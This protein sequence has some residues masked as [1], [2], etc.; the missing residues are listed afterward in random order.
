MDNS[1]QTNSMRTGKEQKIPEEV[2]RHLVASSE[3]VNAMD[4]GSILV[5]PPTSLA[6]IR[7]PEN[8]TNNPNKEAKKTSHAFERIR[9]NFNL[10]K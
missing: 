9:K 8:I 10:S 7:N 3:T 4:V 1:I 6:R 5:I 2:A